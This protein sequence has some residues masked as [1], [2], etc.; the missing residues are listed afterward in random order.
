MKHTRFVGLVPRFTL[1]CV[2]S[3]ARSGQ[4]R[5]ARVQE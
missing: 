3:E 4:M 5:G 1:F 2:L